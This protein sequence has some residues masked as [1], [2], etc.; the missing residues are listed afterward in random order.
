MID[1][2]GIGNGLIKTT[3]GL[4]MACQSPGV[5]GD[6]MVSATSLLGSGLAIADWGLGNCQRELGDGSKRP[7]RTW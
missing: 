7:K 6:C 3:G 2:R 1:Q 5:I 4:V